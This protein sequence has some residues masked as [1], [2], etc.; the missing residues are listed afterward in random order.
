MNY[1]FRGERNVIFDTIPQ[2]NGLIGFEVLSISIDGAEL[3]IN[4]A[5]I[6][7][8]THNN[9]IIYGQKL[10]VSISEIGEAID[11]LVE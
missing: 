1:Y 2:E 4:S 10:E 9:H 8:L 11:L 7:H 3:T 6:I 5:E